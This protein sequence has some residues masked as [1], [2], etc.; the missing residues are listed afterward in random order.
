MKFDIIYKPAFKFVAPSGIQTACPGFIDKNAPLQATLLLN[1]IDYLIKKQ[2]IGIEFNPKSVIVFLPNG[3]VPFLSSEA[4]V[5]QLAAERLEARDAY[6]S[7]NSVPAT[8]NSIPTK[9]TDWKLA[10]SAE[11]V[12][13]LF[14]RKPTSDDLIDLWVINKRLQNQEVAKLLT[15]HSTCK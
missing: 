9:C 4:I 8:K 1:V 12:I 10:S 15:R 14:P 7:R 13:S 11:E 2:A 5:T 3:T 6:I